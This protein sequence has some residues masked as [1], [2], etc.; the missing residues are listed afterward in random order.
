M[1][2]TI[3]GLIRFGFSLIFGLAVSALFAG[4]EMTRKNLLRLGAVCA[5][6]LLVQTVF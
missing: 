1:I 3:F 2:T 6:F 4:I 5:F